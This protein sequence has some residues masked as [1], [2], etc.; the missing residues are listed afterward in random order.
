MRVRS[1]GGIMIQ[2]TGTGSAPA[3]VL[4]A[5]N[6]IE[7][8]HPQGFGVRA[9]GAID[10]VVCDNTFRGAGQDAST[11]AGVYVRAT[12][13]SEDFERAVIE[14]NTIRNFG[15]RGISVNGNGTARLR[16]LE[17]H[18]NRFENDRGTASMTEAISLDDR[19][20]ALQRA[21]V[22]GNH[23]LRGIRAPLVNL[24]RNATVTCDDP[25]PR[26]REAAQTHAASQ[27]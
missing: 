12:N 19:S 11:Y 23:Y 27:P 1:L 17:I 20:G 16:S 21:S 9:E 25:D 15:A 13:P 6:D 18:D 26:S 24:P 3:R 22:T 5:N 10:I 8:T 7:V 14:R 2:G 4:V